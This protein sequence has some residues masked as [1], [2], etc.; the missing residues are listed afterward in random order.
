[1]TLVWAQGY[2]SVCD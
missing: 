1:M 2:R